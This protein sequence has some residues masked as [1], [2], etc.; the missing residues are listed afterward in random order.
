LGGGAVIPYGL[1]SVPELF[2]VRANFCLKK[3]ALAFLT[4][5]VYFFLTSLKLFDANADRHRMFLC[6]SMV[7][8]SGEN[9]GLY[10]FL[11]L[12]F[13]N[14][15]FLFKLVR[16]ALL[17]NN[18]ASSTDGMR[19]IS[20]QETLSQDSDTARTSRLAE[21]AK[22][23]NKTNLGR[24]LLMLLTC[25]K[26]RLLQLQKSTNE[27]T[28]GVGVELGTAWPGLTS[29]SPEEQR[30]SRMRVQLKANRTGSLVRSEQREKG[31][32]FWA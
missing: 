8:R 23:V 31:A 1:Y 16:K 2:G 7:V 12:H 4:A 6:W 17:K 24:R 30:R 5:C 3:L 10:L 15:A 11:D 20:F 19:S 18:Q 9:Q 27:S 26:P 28:W 21:C 32:G 25:M 22:A 29:T 13:L 14:R